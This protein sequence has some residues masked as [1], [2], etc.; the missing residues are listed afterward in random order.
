MEVLSCNGLEIVS[1]LATD[2]VGRAQSI[3]AILRLPEWLLCCLHARS[4]EFLSGLF[5]RGG[6]A[7]L[8]GCGSAS[9]RSGSR[10]RIKINA[11]RSCRRRGAFAT[12][13]I[14]CKGN[15]RDVL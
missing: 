2:I 4:F 9:R 7:R 14:L 8:G 10:S 13:D 5:V 6:G 11:E 15:P 3:Q 12:A 1:M